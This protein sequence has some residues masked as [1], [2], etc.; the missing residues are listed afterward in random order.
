[1]SL[2]RGIFDWLLTIIVFKINSHL[3]FD[4]LVIRITFNLNIMNIRNLDSRLKFSK[5]LQWWSASREILAIIWNQVNLLIKFTGGSYSQF[6]SDRIL[7][8]CKVH[9]TLLYTTVHYCT[10]LYTALA[11]HCTAVYTHFL[12]WTSQPDILT[13]DWKILALDPV[14]FIICN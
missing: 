5:V 3:P 14:W 12:N 9:C 1:M 10:L 6:S 8:R 7:I 11:L 2:L 4:H 13:M